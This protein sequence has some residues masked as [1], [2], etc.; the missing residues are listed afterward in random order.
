MN[1]VSSIFNVDF[2]NYQSEKWRRCVFA[3]KII[4]RKATINYLTANSAKRSQSFR[5]ENITYSKLF[6]IHHW[7]LT[8]HY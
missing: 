7:P 5:K 6:L 4:S 1:V 3:K 2:F 8:I